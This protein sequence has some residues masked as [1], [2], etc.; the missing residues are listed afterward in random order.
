MATFKIIIEDN[1]NGVSI[2]VDNHAQLHGSPAGRVAGALI[3]GARLLDRI[4][5]PVV[6]ATP[7]CPCEVCEAYRE[8]LQTK[9][10][11]H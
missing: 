3:S 10:T 5:L 9:P 1:E 2:S 7:G 11:I 6:S 4:P 8:L